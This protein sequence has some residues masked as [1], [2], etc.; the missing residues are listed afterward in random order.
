M[1]CFWWMI[2]GLF[3]IVVEVIYDPTLGQRQRRSKQ[4]K[5]GTDASSTDAVPHN[6]L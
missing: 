5:D 6:C 1:D 2:I 4:Q 3:L